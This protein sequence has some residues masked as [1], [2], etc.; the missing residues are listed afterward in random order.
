MALKGLEACPT[1]G[2]TRR[3]LPIETAYKKQWRRG[4]SLRLRPKSQDI[5]KYRGHELGR[6]NDQGGAEQREQGVPHVHFQAVQGEIHRGRRQ[7]ERLE[8]RSRRNRKIISDLKSKRGGAWHLVARGRRLRVLLFLFSL[9]SRGKGREGILTAVLFS[10][11][12]IHS[13]FFK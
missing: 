10:K 7:S 3:V 13:R 2:T 4:H 8:H 5:K 9:V 6:K 1:F 11:C 12:K